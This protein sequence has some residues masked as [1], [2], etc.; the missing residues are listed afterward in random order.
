MTGSRKFSLSAA[1]ALFCLIVI[2]IHV[3]SP[4]ISGADRS[5][6]TYACAL[7]LWRLSAFVV[8]GF[9]LTAG[10]KLGLKFGSGKQKWGMY[11]LSRAKRILI[12]YVIWVVVYY[13]WFWWRQYYGFSLSDLVR[14]ILIGDLAAHFYF[15]ITIVQFYALAPFW[16]ALT[17]RLHAATALPA[18][19]FISLL[20]AQYLSDLL[21]LFGIEGFVWSDRVFT[22]YLIWWMAGLYIGRE[23]D[24]FAESLGKSRVILAA[25]T[26]LFGLLD[27]RLV[28]GSWVL[29]EYHAYAEPVHML[30]NAC[31]ILL[32][33][34]LG[35]LV[36]EGSILSKA[37][38]EV[39]RAGYGIYLSHLLVLSAA[40]YVL[41]I[42]GVTGL[43]KRFI[44][45]A[46]V[47]YIVSIA[48]NIGYQRLISYI[49]A[50]K[51]TAR[52]R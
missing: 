28:Y 14:Y 13:L 39:D 27:A 19:A 37:I 52:V 48:A 47:T 18:A 35:Q 2:F 17:D 10:I 29:G 20:S 21:T 44:I 40:A 42:I 45:C 5:T 15:I 22:T 24:I 51:Q 41:D 25:S 16:K 3:I 12:P 34:S 8:Q 26:V 6:A 49:K 46:A 30:Y 11:Y 38:G 50:K 31:A 7:S 1:G 9:V 23:W 4:V 33:L 43:A 36:R 32:V